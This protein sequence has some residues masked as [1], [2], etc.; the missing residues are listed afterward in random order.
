M[1]PLSHGDSMACLPAKIEKTRAT[2][3]HDQLATVARRAA[4]AHHAF[5]SP[6][7]GRA[8]LGLHL[9]GRAGEP[10]FATTINCQRF[11]VEGSAADLGAAARA[12]SGRAAPAMLAP[13]RALDLVPEHTNLW[14]QTDCLLDLHGSIYERMAG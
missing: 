1:D 14:H 7:P 9:P 2:V 6:V 11:T 13:C 4:A 10:S 5:R 12:A 8:G 3:A